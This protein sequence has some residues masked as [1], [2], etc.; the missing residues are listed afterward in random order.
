[1]FCIH[2][3]HIPG[4]R[5]AQLQQQK[6]NALWFLENSSTKQS[7]WADMPPTTSLQGNC[8]PPNIVVS[9]CLFGENDPFK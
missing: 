4:Y 9:Y 6:E 1:L 8:T 5:G 7:L 3:F 2:A